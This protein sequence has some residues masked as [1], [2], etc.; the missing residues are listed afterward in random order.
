MTPNQEPVRAS[1]G[2][3]ETDD[4]SG[5]R[6]AEPKRKGGR[7]APPSGSGRHL[8]N[9]K[10]GRAPG[11]AVVIPQALG[12]KKGRE[13]ERRAGDATPDWDSFLPARSERLPWKVGQRVKRAGD[14]VLSG[15]T[16]LVLAPILALVAV[17]VKMSSRGPVFY[18]CDYVGYRGR[19]FRGYKFRTMVADA[20]E[21]KAELLHL[22]HMNGPAFKIRNDP[23]VTA[24]GR[25]LRKYSIDELPQ[26][27]NVLR[28]DMSL[29]GP[30]PP[31]PE[32][33]A[34]Y[35]EWQRAKLS[36]VPGITC[37]WQIE[38]RSDIVDFDR[39]ARMDL[40]YIDEWSLWEDAKILARTVPAVLLGR[41]A[42]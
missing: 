8:T 10:N 20:D 2:V 11:E 27:W 36:V 32:E 16:L 24:L 34:E 21:K 7:Q 19:R 25:F 26:L 23:R 40:R 37:Y 12:G 14:V 4:R 33:W 29:V 22:N 15:L 9:G 39:W 41:G 6:R 28:G 38:G 3:V 1:D 42:Y 13:Q 35:E 31:L 5:P 30:R 17:L 18:A